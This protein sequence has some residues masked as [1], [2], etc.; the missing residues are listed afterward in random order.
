MNLPD[1]DNPMLAAAAR[2]LELTKQAVLDHPEPAFEHTSER[3]AD[4]PPALRARRTGS[5]A[6]QQ[7]KRERIG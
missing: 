3:S 7:R 1:N 5:R 6:G 2:I 4:T